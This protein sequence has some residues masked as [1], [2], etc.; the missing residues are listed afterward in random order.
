VWRAKAPVFGTN[1]GSYHNKNHRLRDSEAI[2]PAKNPDDLGAA[3]PDIDKEEDTR[4][5][6]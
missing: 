2:N 4:G 3:F 6:E 1:Q 5:A